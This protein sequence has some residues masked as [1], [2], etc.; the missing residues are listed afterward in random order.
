[1]AKKTSGYKLS[2]QKFFNRI[3]TIVAIVFLAVL[4]FKYGY[5]PASDMIIDNSSATIDVGEL[6]NAIN[7]SST[8]NVVEEQKKDTTISLCVVGDIM[9]HN[10]QY[11]DA[12]NSSTDTYDFSHVFSNIA[13]KLQSA[14]LTIGN[15]ETTF[16]GSERG[17][18]SYPTFNT[19]DA[20]AVN[21]RA[22]G[23][24]VL[25]TANNHSLDKGFSG[26]SRTLDVLD[27]NGISHMGTYAS[28]EDSNEILVKDVNGVKI[29]ML[30][31]TYGTNGIPVPS[32]KEFCINLIDKDKIKSD[33]DK[34][35]ALEVD[36]ITVNMHWGAEYRL[37]P[38]TEQENL[39]D[40]LFKNGVDLIF[41][42]H[43]HVLE[44]MEKRTI[45]LEDGTEKEVFLIYSL[46]NFV[47]GQ[48]K[49]Y[50]NLSVILDLEITKRAEGNI[51]I[52]KVE[53][54]PIYVD[55]RSS[56][57]DERFKILDIKES[58]KAYENGDTSISKTLYSKLTSALEKIDK[59]ISGDI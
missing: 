41:G 16:A 46:G 14:D 2:P 37:K 40:F 48:T 54:T 18:S 28:E 44:P 34:A 11:N 30:S 32:G 25:S 26:L 7:G 17:Y 12:Y 35:K 42:S 33:L 58:I 15:L 22:I 21:L 27:E 13:D 51:T 47:S 49:E 23:F 53:Y 57:A 52:D 56:S 6:Q 31:Y 8:E 3:M 39:A 1:M 36:L 38:T 24:D 55:M 29:A 9:C 50:T 45:T 10:T 5:T 43:P 19:P 4:F 20:L 59:I